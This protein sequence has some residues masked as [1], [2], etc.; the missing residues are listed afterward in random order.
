MPP[1][2]TTLPRH[3]PRKVSERGT[4]TRII[5]WVVFLGLGFFAR[6]WLL[7]LWIFADLL[8]DAFDSWVVPVLGFV[9]LPWTTLTYAFM[10]TIDSD[11]VSGWEWIV[12]GIALLVD[13]VFWAWS[14]SAF[15]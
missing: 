15:K 6:L 14:R 3:N 8:G 4:S 2:S 1:P 10:W 7:G 5:A 13:F 9:L 12:V 11:K